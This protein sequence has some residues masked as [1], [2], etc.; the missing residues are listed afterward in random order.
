M[1]I[2][3]ENIAEILLRHGAN[4]FKTDVMGHTPLQVAESAG[5][6][7]PNLIFTFRS[8]HKYNNFL[9][10]NAEVA[11][12]LRTFKPNRSYMGT[13]LRVFTQ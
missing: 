9:S 3:T 7:Q 8:E 6:Y 10:G 11:N 13:V 12:V 5:K 2:G 1:R 4:V